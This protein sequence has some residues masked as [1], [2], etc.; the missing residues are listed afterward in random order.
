MNIRFKFIQPCWHLCLNDKSNFVSEKFDVMLISGLHIS[1]VFVWHVKSI[2][3]WLMSAVTSLLR[4]ER[5]FWLPEFVKVDDSCFIHGLINDSH[6]NNKWFRRIMNIFKGV[7]LHGP[8]SNNL[9]FTTIPKYRYF[10]LLNYSLAFICNFK[11]KGMFTYSTSLDP[12]V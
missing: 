6:R 4:C 8:F 3:D 12:I 11:W 2:A 9:N 10:P 7:W 1:I 5:S